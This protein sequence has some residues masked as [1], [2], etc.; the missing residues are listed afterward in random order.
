MPA[1]FTHFSRAV[2]SAISLHGRLMCPYLK[3][4]LKCHSKQ[5]KSKHTCTCF[6][7]L[8]AI[9]WNEMQFSSSNWKNYQSASHLDSRTKINFK[10]TC[11]QEK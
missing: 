6:E 9:A 4:C 1:D 5:C 3:V 11:V 10:K 2:R 7:W 8:A